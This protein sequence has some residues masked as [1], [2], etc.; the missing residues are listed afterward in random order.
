LLSFSSNFLYRP[1]KNRFPPRVDV[2]K[3]GENSNPGYMFCD[4]VATVITNTHKAFRNS[5]RFKDI[6][7]RTDE[8]VGP[9]LFTQVRAIW[10][11]IIFITDC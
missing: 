1:V 7:E 11:F 6:L 4:A 2:D 5:S 3:E 10:F 9:L 8:L